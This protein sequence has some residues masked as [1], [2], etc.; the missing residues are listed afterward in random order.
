MMYT[1]MICVDPSLGRNK[2]FSWSFV[3]EK[4]GL[5]GGGVL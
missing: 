2:G 1:D 5:N 3:W 4:S